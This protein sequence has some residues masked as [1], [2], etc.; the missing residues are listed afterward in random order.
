MMDQDRA[1]SIFERLGDGT[2]IA[3]VVDD[4]YRRVLADDRLRPAFAG[5]DLNALRR[6]Q[7]HFL[8]T[9]LGAPATYQGRSMRAAHAGRGITA[10]QFAAV[11]GHL[12]ASLTAASVPP[13][14]VDQVIA[15][16][17]PLAPEIVEPAAVA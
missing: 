9:A 13:A 3:A 16:V 17:A 8:A 12:A 10:D 7:T 14:I 4:F 11:A 15:R 2:A 5:V 6:H 1:V